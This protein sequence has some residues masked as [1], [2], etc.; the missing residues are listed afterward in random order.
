VRRALLAA[1][2]A[3]LVS[4]APAHAELKAIWGPNT[5]P[6]GHSA[7]PT[8]QKLHVDVLER[9]LLWNRV[10]PTRP[11]HPR[12]PHDPAYHWPSDLDLAAVKTHDLGMR[13]AL[14]IKDAPAWENGGRGRAWQPIRDSDYDDCAIAAARHYRRVHL[15]MVWGEPA[16]PESFAP[17]PPDSPVGVQRYARLLDSAYGAL[18]SVRRSNIVIGGATFDG[19]LPNLKQWLRWLRLPNGKPPRL[20]WFSHNP[21]GVRYPRLSNPPYNPVVRDMSDVDTYVHAIRRVYARIHRRPKL[22][23]SEFNV[24]SDHA[25]RGFTFFVSRRAQAHWL[26]AAYRI[27]HEEPYIA[28]L[29]WF[30]LLDESG[31]SGLTGGL[32]TP[33]GNRKPAWRAYRHAR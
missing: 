15:W 11:K 8:Y 6:N 19:Q 27:A 13:L 7:F 14:M 4:A 12:N 21:Y 26:T 17:L 31:R 25:S 24:Q 3:L 33:V 10:A 5:L 20:D 28:G 23:L 16:R 29:G 9:Q 22:W 30:E 2:T 18:K 32:M 1:L